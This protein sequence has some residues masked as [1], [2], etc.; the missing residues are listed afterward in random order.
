M[1]C[2]T[3]GVWRPAEPRVAID[4]SPASLDWDSFSLFSPSLTSLP[5]GRVRLFYGGCRETFGACDA[6]LAG[7]GSATS[8]TGG[9]FATGMST[10]TATVAVNGP[11]LTVMVAVPV[12]TAVTVPLVLRLRQ[13]VG[14]FAGSVVDDGG[15]VIALDG[16]TGVAETVRGRW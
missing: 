2:D 16:V 11:E 7:I 15:A 8:M 12:V 14:T 10:L 9:G 4:V 6:V 13:C 3:P 1:R 5:S